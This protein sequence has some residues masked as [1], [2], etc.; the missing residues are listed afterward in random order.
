MNLRI[1]AA[2]N[3]ISTESIHVK[4]LTSI[5]MTMVV[6]MRWIRVIMGRARSKNRHI[7]I[8]GKHARAL[9]EAT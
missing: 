4:Y 9:N 6:A 7:N 3:I 5:S 2:V 1:S 8:I